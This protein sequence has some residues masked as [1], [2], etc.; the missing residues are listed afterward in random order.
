M[1]IHECRLQKDL[2]LNGALRSVE[3]VIRDLLAEI[4]SGQI[5][6]RNGFENLVRGSK[7]DIEAL[8]RHVLK[9]NW[10]LSAVEALKLKLVAGTV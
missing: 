10:Y 3:G 1:H 8:Y 7:L 5:L 6:E 9:E 2:H 4:N